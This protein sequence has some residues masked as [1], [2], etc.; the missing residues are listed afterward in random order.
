MIS[1]EEFEEEK[2]RK[3]TFEILKLEH[4]N[5]RTQDKTKDQ[6]INRIY[7]IIVDGVSDI[8]RNKKC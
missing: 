2:I 8:L 4:T 7:R 6:I 3:M 5:L 1:A